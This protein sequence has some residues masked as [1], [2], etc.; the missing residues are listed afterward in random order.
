MEI[1]TLPRLGQTMES[2]VVGKWHVDVG[3]SFAEGELLYEVETDKITTDVEARMDGVLLR[4]LVGEDDEIPVGS[5]IAVVA[6]AG[7]VV[8]DDDL[9]SFLA[10][11]GA[12]GGAAVDQAPQ[13]A[14]PSAPEDS[15]ATPSSPTSAVPPVDSPAGTILAVP[16]ARD[17]A[18]RR[19]VD[20]ARV[21]GSGVDGVIRVVDV[22]SAGRPAP[23]PDPVVERP[24]APAPAPAPAAVV[25]EQVSAR[26]P[27]R[28]IRK[29]MAETMSANW[30][31]VPQFTQQ[32]TVDATAL[33]ARRARL[34]Y[35]GVSVTYNDLLVAA[36]A[37]VASEHP[38]VN[39][40]FRDDEILHFDVVNVSIAV[41]T[42]EGLVVPVIHDAHRLSVQE[43]GAR[44]QD[45]AERGRA[46]RLTAQDMADGTITVSNL[47]AMGI[48]S[49]SAIVNAPQA[50]IVFVGAMKDV[51]VV[52][53]GQIVVRAQL[54]VSVSFDHRVVDGMTA[55]RFTAA[56]KER[57]ENGG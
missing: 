4:V 5:A 45:L 38:D 24:P 13:A 16:K 35:E 20:L 56:L 28:G 10:E 34:G 47:G 23:T 39:G 43:I 52:R 31:R 9:A 53:E 3:A 27:L 19:G 8:S 57:L 21:A 6:A 33:K 18:R 22:L 12:P 40:S 44:A 41:A 7:E 14:E 54:G 36:V 2:G 15:A 42:D 55:A 25:G 51:P 17:I 48:E 46:R 26:L 30:P 32:I 11:A 50:A 1:V 49:G 37:Q 29:A